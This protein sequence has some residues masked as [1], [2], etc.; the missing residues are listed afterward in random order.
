MSPQNVR[1]SLDMKQHNCHVIESVVGAW[2]CWHCD[3]VVMLSMGGTLKMYTTA[4]SSNRNRP[5][6]LSE[7]TLTLRQL[8][9][10]VT[11]SY[12]SPS[13]PTFWRVVRLL[14]CQKT[15]TESFG[16]ETTAGQVNT[17]RA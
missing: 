17:L 10:G 11:P 2:R 1:F 12:D 16:H 9:Y 14:H 3:V 4:S 13:T 15:T 5:L 8:Q 7:C 6:K